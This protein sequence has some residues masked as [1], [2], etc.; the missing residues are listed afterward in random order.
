MNTSTEVIQTPV[1]EQ[2]IPLGQAAPAEN[3]GTDESAA[4]MADMAGGGQ[5][6]DIGAPKRRLRVSSQIVLMA[7]VLILSAAALYFMRQL[8]TGA[9]MTFVQPPIDF[10]LEQDQPDR[11]GEHERMIAQLEALGITPQ[12]PEV[13]KNPFESIEPVAVEEAPD[14]PDDGSRRQ[15]ERDRQIS[16]ALGSVVL[17]SI[18]QGNRPMA[19]V[20]ER[21]VTI[22]DTVADI[23]TIVEIGDRFIVVEVD[24]ETHTIRMKERSSKPVRRRPRR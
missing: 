3:A 24:D 18:I 19:N 5:Q 12:V 9:G 4:I 22:G 6:L 15:Q 7:S 16:M 14:T 11:L 17:H 20:N 8:G 10:F 1:D 23:L 2:F 13:D 21:L